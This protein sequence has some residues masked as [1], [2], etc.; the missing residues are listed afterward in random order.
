MQAEIFVLR[1]A[2]LVEVLGP[3]LVDEETAKI[4]LINAINQ[5]TRDWLYRQLCNTPGNDVGQTRDEQLASISYTGLM[6]VLSGK[7]MFSGAT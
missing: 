3:E 1:F 4:S 2:K 5:P 6:R 7:N